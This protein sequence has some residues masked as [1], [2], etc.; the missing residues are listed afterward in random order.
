MPKTIDLLTIFTIIY[1][2]KYCMKIINIYYFELKYKTKYFIKT[3]YC[4][5]K[6]VINK[7]K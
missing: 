2:Y 4:N 1:Y 6:K 5:Y 3:I 7:S